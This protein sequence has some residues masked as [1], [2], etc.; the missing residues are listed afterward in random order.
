LR[1]ERLDSMNGILAF[2]LNRP[3]PLVDHD[4]FQR[5]GVRN[6]DR[7]VVHLGQHSVAKG[8]P[9]FRLYRG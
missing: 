2:D 9:D 1:I 8:E 5:L 4:Q 3:L 7:G 6:V